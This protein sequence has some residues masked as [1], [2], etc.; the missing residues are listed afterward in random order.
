MKPCVRFVIFATV[1]AILFS[2]L[3]TA[4][5]QQ[6]SGPEGGSFTSLTSNSTTLF[7][8]VNNGGGTNVK[9]ELYYSTDQGDS[10][11]VRTTSFQIITLAANGSVVLAG[12]KY[13]LFRSSDNG[14][15]WNK[16][17]KDTTQV[18]VY[19]VGKIF[20]ATVSGINGK[21]YQS[22]DNGVTW[23][24]LPIWN[25]IQS[26][27]GNDSIIFASTY[28]KDAIFCSVNKGRTWDSIAMPKDVMLLHYYQNT[29]FYVSSYNKVY[30]SSD[31]GITWTNS[32]VIPQYDVM[33]IGSN[34]IALFAITD[35]GIVR[36]TD[37]GATWIE[38]TNGLPKSGFNSATYIYNDIGNRLFVINLNAIYYTTTNGDSWKPLSSKGIIKTRILGLIPR[39]S[40]IL[41]GGMGGVFRSVNT[42]L[43][44]ART[45]FG[46]YTT[47][48]AAKDSLVIAVGG[49]LPY[50]SSDN[51]ITWA[52][53][54]SGKYKFGG[55]CWGIEFTS[56]GIFI[57]LSSI[58]GSGGYGYIIRSVDSG[59]I[60]ERQ[61]DN[62]YYFE[63]FDAKGDTLF[64]GT[65]GLGISR[66]TDF[67][68]TWTLVSESC[69]LISFLLSEDIQFA[70]TN[71]GILRSTNGGT[72]WQRVGLP[73]LGAVAFA[74][75]G[76]T[77]FAASNGSPT[78]VFRS[79]DLGETWHNVSGGLGNNVV[80]S[81]AVFGATLFAGT[82]DAGIWKAE[83][84]D[85]I[86][87]S[88]AETAESAGLM[89][90]P[91]PAHDEITVV[92]PDAAQTTF[93]VGCRLV[94][95]DGRVIRQFTGIDAA[96]GRFTFPLE[97]IESG[98]YALELHAGTYYSCSRVLIHR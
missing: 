53:P 72:S 6:T 27:T 60:W 96:A 95:S 97:G 26:L 47:C 51:C 41:A 40:D 30:R 18:D 73:K 44:W 83:I 11:N 98:V 4:Q 66:S 31:K 22:S 74:R 42:G 70:G 56:K 38:I 20:Y 94:T 2:S 13:G 32:T 86:H 45:G 55:S 33:S 79:D 61:G 7:G 23:D 87:S 25:N 5:W 37:T 65:G 78:G 71:I 29:L 68:V 49:G 93:P 43:S 8:I 80:T 62:T 88:V 12:T 9:N 1:F 63:I 85:L 3:S 52:P 39:S 58:T 91:T 54:D 77:F 24:V 21:N 75:Y 28:S 16:S 76:N 19:S 64:I 35:K 84:T 34:A 92:L 14:T 36:S 69:Y 59:K 82:N 50:H 17:I 15:T 46:N 10:W 81:L 48:L 90:Y 67:G 57:G 89:V